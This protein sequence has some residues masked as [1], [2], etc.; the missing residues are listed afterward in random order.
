M[1]FPEPS[2][3]KSYAPDSI[4]KVPRSNSKRLGSSCLGG[5][6]EAKSIKFA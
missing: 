5:N 6:R 2:G 4:L 1:F 3:G